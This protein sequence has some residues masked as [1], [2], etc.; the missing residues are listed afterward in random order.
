MKEVLY[1]QCKIIV[2][3]SEFKN[4]LVNDFNINP[5][6]IFVSSTMV[7]SNIYSER[8]HLEIEMKNV[9]FCRK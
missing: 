3:A 1:F 4:S 2:L 8:Y 7:E 6:K 9:L 5:D